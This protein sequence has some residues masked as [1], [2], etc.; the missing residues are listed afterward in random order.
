MLLVI[1]R[2]DPPNRYRSLTN[3]APVGPLG[4]VGAS[5]SVVL[6]S[7]SWPTAKLLLNPLTAANDVTFCTPL[8][9]GT[10]LPLKPP[11]SSRPGCVNC[12]VCVTLAPLNRN[13]VPLPTVL[14]PG[15][16]FNVFH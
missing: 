10:G 6:V 11:A 3:S 16:T 2:R 14:V 15:I 7:Q 9:L 4:I 12:W 8:L 5:A 1:T 13:S